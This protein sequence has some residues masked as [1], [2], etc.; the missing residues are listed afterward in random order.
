MTN[1][2][3]DAVNLCLD[4]Y[5]SILENFPPEGQKLASRYFDIDCRHTR[6]LNKL[7]VLSKK[8]GKL[9]L[10]DEQRIEK[11]LIDSKDL[12]DR[13]FEISECL[14]N[15]VSDNMF[16]LDRNLKNIEI[17]QVDPC[18]PNKRPK[19]M[20]KWPLKYSDSIDVLKID[21]SS[22][23]L[24]TNLTKVNKFQK[25]NVQIKTNLN[26]NIQTSKT[27]SIDTDQKVKNNTTHTN[28]KTQRSK[29]IIS[30][31]LD[32]DN[33]I[34]PTYCICEEVS[35]GNMVCCDNDLCPIEWFHF[36]CVS[37]TRKPKGKWYCPKCRGI[38][39]KTMKSR[40]TFFKELKE[41]NKLKEEHFS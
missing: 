29:K 37:L 27:M 20:L 1:E 14:L 3:P 12:G 10:S 30:K 36:G 40:K 38:N 9:S 24:N 11:I 2:L 15:M 34:E 33:E 22:E 19:R 6:N 16:N 21:K 28:S 41:Y 13:K 23:H 35:Y 4:N 26:K 18:N 31:S 39:S 8:P 32:S 25:K 17:T 5:I 7:T